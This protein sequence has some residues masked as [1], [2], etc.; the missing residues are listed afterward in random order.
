MKNLSPSIDVF[1]LLQLCVA[2]NLS[3]SEEEVKK[4][5]TDLR[6]DWISTRS[7]YSTGYEGMI[8]KFKGDDS[9]VL[10]HKGTDYAMKQFITGITNV[11][12]L[13]GVLSTDIVNDAEIFLGKVV[14]QI[15]DALASIDWIAR[16]YPNPKII[17]VGYSLGG[18]LAQAGYFISDNQ[19]DSYI[20]ESPGALEILNKYYP[21]IQETKKG[22]LEYYFRSADII[23]SYG[24]RILST[25]HPVKI[26]PTDL[27]F[28]SGVKDYV[29]YTIDV[30]DPDNFIEDF[31]NVKIF[32]TVSAWPNG[33][34]KGF[35]WYISKQNSA[36]WNRIAEINIFPKI[37][38]KL[39]LD[40]ENEA[41]L[42]KFITF[43]DNNY[44]S[45][46]SSSF[47]QALYSTNLDAIGCEYVLQYQQ[48]APSFFF[49]ASN[50]LCLS[51]C[52]CVY[53]PALTLKA[54]YNYL[55]G[56]N[57]NTKSEGFKLLGDSDMKDLVRLELLNVQESVVKVHGD[58]N[59]G[60]ESLI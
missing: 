34:T 47:N 38:D 49:K 55:F 31:R 14:P 2:Q 21:E 29:K 59:D 37:C 16:E 28:G 9:I 6:F 5:G 32:E 39:G 15:K 30:H 24:T 57:Y 1:T 7:N 50:F 56:N 12:S 58:Y 19:M 46:D 8:F 44:L 10:F 20:F 52:C 42:A 4:A 25:S 40:P 45:T 22:I 18:F 23:N 35:Q 51:C 36:Y 33:L 60:L 48:N 41:E 11:K 53:V 17:Q 43:F 26:M 27:L 54:G 13:V 3:T